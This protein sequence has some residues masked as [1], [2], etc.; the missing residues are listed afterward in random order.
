PRARFPKLEFVPTLTG[1]VP[2]DPL[3]SGLVKPLAERTV[4]IGYRGRRLPHHY[5]RLGYEKLVIGLEMK[6]LASEVGIEVDIEVDEDKRIYGAGWYAFLG[7]CR[8]TLGTESGS[9]VFDDD[10]SLAR[11]SN[12]FDNLPFEA[13]E[14]RFLRGRDGVVV[15][16]NQIS[17]KVFE[18]IR[19]RTA[20]IL[21]EGQ[22]SGVLIPN[23]HYIPLRKDFSN[24]SKVF[25][26]LENLKFLSEM[27][28]RAYDEIFATGRYSYSNFVSGVDGFLTKRC[29][30]GSRYQIMSIPA[31]VREPFYGKISAARNRDSL[32]SASAYVGREVPRENLSS[33]LKVVGGF[34]CTGSPALTHLSAV[35]PAMPTSAMTLLAR[36]WHLLPAPVRYKLAGALR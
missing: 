25:E 7:S 26:L 22:Y 17:P 28:D 18:A 19:L 20:L 31:I 1:Y 9:N 12:Q 33:A 13:F 14:A 23:R 30:H 4:R 5:G 21:F 35:M 3:I 36:G 11:L 32:I 34:R 16:M 10:G 6:R 8:A 29:P 15:K 24:A 27:T 2:E